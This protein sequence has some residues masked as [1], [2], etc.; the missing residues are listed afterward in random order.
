M[1][2]AVC[3]SKPLLEQG[4]ER[5]PS[6]NNFEI[7]SIKFS[8]NFDNGNLFQVEKVPNKSFEYRIWTAPDNT[9]TEYESKHSTWFYFTV[10]GLP[11]GCTIKLV[12]SL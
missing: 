3:F 7:D 12:S 9:G 4:M 8:S 10:I 2:E 11:A 1:R 5:Y 6:Q